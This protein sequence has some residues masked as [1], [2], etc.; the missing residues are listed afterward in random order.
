MSSRNGILV[1]LFVTAWRILF[2]AFDRTDLFVDEAQYWLWS[3]H[4]DLGYYSKPP[5][6]AW[7]LSAVTAVLGSDSNFAI[8]VAGPLL[9][10]LNAFALMAFAR[11]VAGDRAVGWTGA[12]YVTL[13]AVGLSSWLFSTDVP[14]ILFATLGLWAYI[15]LTKARS[16]PLAILMGA[17]VGLAFLSKYAVL[18]LVPGGAAAMALLP[19]ARISVR[20]FALAV[21][22][23][24]LVAAPNLVWNLT[25]DITTVRHTQDIAHWSDLKLNLSGAVEFF[26]AQ[27]AVVGPIIF[28]A[29]LWASWL[30]IRKRGDVT[31]RH[32]F[33]LSMPVIALIT[34]QALLA[35]AYANWAVLAYIAGAVMAVSLLQNKWPRGLRI[36]LAING[37]LC[38]ILPVLLVVAPDLRL[39]NGRLVLERYL[40]RSEMSREIARIAGREELTTIVSDNRDVLADLF[41]TMRDSS[42]K[43][44]ARPPTGFPDNYYEQTLALSADTAGP[45]LYVS[46]RPLTCDGTDVP[47]VTELAPEDG[48]YRNRGLKAYRVDAE[49]LRTGIN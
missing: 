8:R 46:R 22:V 49:C 33:W 19:S 43:F 28:S 5:M 4:L 6:I 17:A 45:V 42:L 27:F 15:G 36:S 26:L 3:Q 11:Q 14:L 1:I 16:V 2:L 24:G 30:V 25:H 23:A 48:Y 39:P 12:T 41:H 47:A 21:V 18:F 31:R 13:P 37:A 10:M 34:L 20:D 35:K 38:L 9:H 29:M 7:I 44:R 40:G 32:L